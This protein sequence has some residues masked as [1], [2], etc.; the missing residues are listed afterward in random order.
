[1]TIQE[2]CRRSARRRVRQPGIAGVRA[3]RP[4]RPGRWFRET[5]WRHLVGIVMLVFSAFPL[6]YVLSA[7]LNPAARC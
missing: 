5:G 6:V 3:R 1:M 4:R 2:A 7:S